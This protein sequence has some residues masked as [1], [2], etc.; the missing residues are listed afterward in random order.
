MARIT[1][2]GSLN[3]DLVVRTPRIPKPG[4]TIIGSDFH[5][6]PGGKG[7]NQA[8]A[9]AKLG[10]E[11]SMVGR[12]GEDDFG[13]ALIANLEAVHVNH[14]FVRRDP[15]TPTG[16]ALIT[17]EDSGENNI[18]L[19]PGS[20][21]KLTVEDIV[22]AGET[23][24]QSDSVLFQLESP[25]PVVEAALELAKSRGVTTILNPAPA[26]PLSEALLRYVDILV[27]NETETALL[28]GLP[29][30][31]DAQI[32]QAAEHLR[33]IGVGTVILTLGERGAF[34]CSAAGNRHVPAYKIRPVDTTAAGDAFLGGFAVA[35]GEGSSLEE[36]V[37]RG[38]AAGAVAATRFGAQPSL[39]TRD[40]WQRLIRQR[41]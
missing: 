38:N 25:L 7:A 18:V 34:L 31:T 3:M 37:S 23:I 13:R 41:A 39:P 4:E 1:V 24:A 9:A 32:E 14:R 11:V 22:A 10:A 17:V 16:I 40:E 35:L 33:R 15:V 26:Q 8:V 27:P 28:T 6:I 2:V 5:T 19:A 21:M 36:A 30:A 20:N 12:V 29:V